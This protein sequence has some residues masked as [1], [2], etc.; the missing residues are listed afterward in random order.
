MESQQ[1]SIEESVFRATFAEKLADMGKNTFAEK[2][3]DIGKAVIDLVSDEDSQAEAV[4]KRNRS[5][6]EAAPSTPSQSTRPKRKTPKP[7][8]LQGQGELLPPR[9]KT[10]V[11]RKP[12]KGCN[13]AKAAPSKPKAASCT[14]FEIE[15]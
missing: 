12:A 14:A 5:C 2:L 9:P 8:R 15:V 4:P 3:A 6:G 13:I 1:I 10:M 11:K 7:A